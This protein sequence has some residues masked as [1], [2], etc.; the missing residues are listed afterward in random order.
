M[1]LIEIMLLTGITTLTILFFI[2]SE[3][4]R[5]H[6]AFL[7]YKIRL[8]LNAIDDQFNSHMSL[9]EDLN[10]RIEALELA[11]SILQELLRSKR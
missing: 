11:G 2:Y 5:R 9:L 7:N 8:T 3:V 6:T 1:T 10:E 4:Q